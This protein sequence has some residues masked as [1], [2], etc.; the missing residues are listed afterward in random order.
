LSECAG[1][2]DGCLGTKVPFGMTIVERPFVTKAARARILPSAGVPG[3]GRRLVG[4]RFPDRRDLRPYAGPGAIGNDHRE[5]PEAHDDVKDE[6]RHP[7]MRLREC[8]RK[9]PVTVPPQCSLQEAAG[10]MAGHGIGALLVVN[11]DELVGIL[12]DRDIAL[13]GVGCG[14]GCSEHVSA[15]MTDAPITVQGSADILDAFRV[16]HDAGV[17]RLPVLEE[18]EVAGIITV[19]DLLVWLAAE[20]AA[21]ATPVADDVLHRS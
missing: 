10:L 9:A 21:I 2:R 12:T 18:D 14:L 1:N 4:P 13:R 7:A 6:R 5:A 3:S 11:G 20:F 17:R 8:L 16:L 15:V 19:D